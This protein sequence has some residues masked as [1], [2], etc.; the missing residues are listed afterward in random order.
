M[1]QTIKFTTRLTS[2]EKET[3]L[4]YDFLTKTWRMDSTVHKHFN[5]AL[6]QGWTPLVKYEYE[7][8]TVAGYV[9]EAPGRAITIRNVE[10]K[11][12]SDK[13]LENLS[14]LYDI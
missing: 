6:N 4:N 9:L 13:Q 12:M 8:G 2:E 7:D 1:M 14:S 5:K 10:A 3:L 11:K